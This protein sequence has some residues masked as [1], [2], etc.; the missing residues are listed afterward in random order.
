MTINCDYQLWLTKAAINYKI[1]QDHLLPLPVQPGAASLLRVSQS[2]TEVP[3]CCCCSTSY[4][5]V[6]PTSGLMQFIWSLFRGDCREHNSSQLYTYKSC[7]LINLN[8]HPLYTLA[9]VSHARS[10][11]WNC[12][13]D[14][15]RV[16]STAKPPSHNSS[17][18]VTAARA[19]VIKRL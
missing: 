14:P 6:Q 13:I 5:H 1:C 8:P 19:L 4:L 18:H 11:L 12:S 9:E 7:F 10:Y 15:R 2:W 17:L 16:S 3:S